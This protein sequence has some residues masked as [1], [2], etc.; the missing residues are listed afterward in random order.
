[1]Y[2]A[3]LVERVTVGVQ[4]VEVVHIFWTFARVDATP[5]WPALPAGDLHVVL[6]EALVEHDP[7]IGDQE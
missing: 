1:M 3:S 5:E 4:V 7:A 6:N 2:F